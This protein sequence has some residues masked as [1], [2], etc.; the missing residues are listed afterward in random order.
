MDPSNP[1][2]FQDVTRCPNPTSAAEHD[3]LLH[4]LTRAISHL[5]ARQRLVLALQYIHGLNS[6][7]IGRVMNLPP[8]DVRHLQS[9]ATRQLTGRLSRR[10]GPRAV[11]A[12]VP[13][14]R[15]LD[16]ALAG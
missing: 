4:T 9:R 16:Q 8:A 1:L 3:A 15:C 13:M 6:E 12:P 11:T 14:D 5:T 10:A 7:E 2:L